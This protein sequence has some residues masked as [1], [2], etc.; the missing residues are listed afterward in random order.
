MG[1]FLKISY[2]LKKEVIKVHIF[3]WQTQ[4]NG[5]SF[6]KETCEHILENI[7]MSKAWFPLW[8]NMK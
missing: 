8:V 7:A 3:R 4:K 2:Y 1:L 6:S 5:V